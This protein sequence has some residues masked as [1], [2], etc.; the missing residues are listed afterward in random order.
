MS[1]PSAAQN[2]PVSKTF[3]QVVRAG[4]ERLIERDAAERPRNAQPCVVVAVNVLESHPLQKDEFESLLHE[5][6]ANPAEAESLRTGRKWVASKFGNGD[7]AS[8]RLAAGLSQTQLAVLCEMSQPHVSRY[9]SGKH[10]PMTSVT[11]KLAHAL[12]VPM[13]EVFRAWQM[14]RAA[15][16]RTEA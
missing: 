6:E 15:A 10:E 5:M 2:S 13:E 14:S 8:L 16:Q 3:V 12:N 4:S 7:L 1:L 11:E 9:E